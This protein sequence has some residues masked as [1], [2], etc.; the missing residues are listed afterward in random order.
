MA[1]SRYYH[2]EY[3]KAEV[4]AIVQALDRGQSVSVI[5]PPSVG[6]TNLLRFLDQER[7]ATSDPDS[8]W[9]QYAPQ[10]AEQGPVVAINID[11]NALLPSLPQEKGNV[12]AAAWPGFEMLVHRATI[13][14]QL[15]PVYRPPRD[16][17][18]DDPDLIEHIGRLQDRFNNAHPDVTDFEDRLHAHLALRHLESILDAALTGARLQETPIRIAF[19]MDEF[20]RLLV[21]M[22]DY[23]FVALRSIRDR[24]K[25][26]VMF[27]T[28]TRNSLAY[29]T[30]NRLPVL[31]PF[32]ELFHDSTVCLRPFADDDAWRMIE[33]LEKRTV[34]KDDY[35]LGLLIRATGGFAGLLRAGFQH[36]EKLAPIQAPDYTQ[37][38]GL[39]AS[40]LSAEPNVQAE[41]ET[42]LRGL[43]K[44]EIAA[45]YAVAG[46]TFEYSPTIAREL[47]NK[48][49]LAQDTQGTGVHIA[50][51]V[52]AAFI[53]NNPK[54]PEAHAAV[55]PVTL[56]ES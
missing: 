43:N 11:P 32:I 50:P 35:S 20:E 13:T 54:P 12:A 6:K 5:G 51:P 22:P 7:L 18:D 27:V 14:P 48:S 2:P 9:N 53:R 49:L 33:Q 29:L 4:S 37:A 17:E 56:P 15:Y 31:E 25:Y 19:F 39:A 40:R 47:V 36:A 1:K 55:P 10:S 42:L 46:G 38:V 44:E 21:T 8:P 52:L 23:F 16:G 41:C 34:S 3:R 45:L 30:G 28:F 24:F 26:N